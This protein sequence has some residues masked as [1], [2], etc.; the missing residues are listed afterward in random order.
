MT[1]KV[2]RQSTLG[3]MG[4]ASISLIADLPFEVAQSCSGE[5]LYLHSVP[6]PSS[7]PGHPVQILSMPEQQPSKAEKEREKVREAPSKQ[8]KKTDGI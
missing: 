8:K 5:S 6:D 3:L 4:P 1:L 2:I 7:V